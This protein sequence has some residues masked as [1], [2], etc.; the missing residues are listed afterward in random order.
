MH[1]MTGT[2]P[3]YDNDLRPALEQVGSTQWRLV[4]DWT[5]AWKKGERRYRVEV[6]AGYTFKPTVPRIFWPAV[7]PTETLTASLLHDYLYANQDDA[8]VR[9]WDPAAERW[10]DAE[11]HT[12]RQADALFLRIMRQQKQAWWRRWL[13]YLAVRALG[14]AWYVVGSP[15]EAR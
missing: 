10:G 6:P 15:F 2:E 14:W 1:I 12:R 5:Y 7:A 9:R 13:A 11:P 4:D 3:T 8:I